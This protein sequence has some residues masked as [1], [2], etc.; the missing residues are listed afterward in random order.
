MASALPLC[1]GREGYAALD[2]WLLTSKQKPDSIGMV[3]GTP[4]DVSSHVWGAYRV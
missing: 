3:S 1:Q 4:S 2:T